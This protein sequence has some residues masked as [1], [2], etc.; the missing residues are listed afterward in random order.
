MQNM[1]FEL[2]AVDNKSNARAG[3]LSTGHGLIETPIF[4][5]VGTA[6]SVKAVHQKELTEEVKAQSILGNTTAYIIMLAIGLIF[7]ITNRLWMRNI[8]NRMMKRRY[9]NM[10]AF[11]AS[12]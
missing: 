5:P 11:R 3:V 4:M 10:E 1:V 9:I 12:R 6:G 8:Y 7:I 2:K